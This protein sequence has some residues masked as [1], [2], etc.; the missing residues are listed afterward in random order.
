MPEFILSNNALSATEF[1]GIYEV[2]WN[3]IQGH[4]YEAVPV[5]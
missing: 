1:S 5:A 2:D 4:L 3:M